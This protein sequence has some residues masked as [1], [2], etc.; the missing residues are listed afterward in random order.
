MNNDKQGLNPQ[1]MQ[2][3]L[4]M[5]NYYDKNGQDKLVQD[6]FS[7]VANQKKQG[8]LTNAQIEQFVKNVSPLLNQNQKQKLNE[9]AKQLVEI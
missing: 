2:F 1:Q 3:I 4:Q 6:I 8:K 9:L 5:I 7:N